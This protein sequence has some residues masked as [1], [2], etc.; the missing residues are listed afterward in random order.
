MRR[1]PHASPPGYG[2]VTRELQKTTTYAK[3]LEE[4]YKTAC[5]QQKLK[6][7]PNKKLKAKKRKTQNK[8]NKKKKEWVNTQSGS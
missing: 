3:L 5:K 2:K 8:Q 1:L 6:W 4:K 7:K